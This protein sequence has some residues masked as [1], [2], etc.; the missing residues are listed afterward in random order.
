LALDD[1]KVHQTE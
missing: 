1:D